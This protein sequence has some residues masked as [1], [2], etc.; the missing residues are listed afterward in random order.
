M[1]KNM[2]DQILDSL[3]SREERLSNYLTENTISEADLMERYAVEGM[4]GR[5]GSFDYHT[6]AK[7]YIESTMREM[8]KGKEGNDIN[9][10]FDKAINSIAMGVKS[11]FVGNREVTN[12]SLLNAAKKDKRVA[13]LLRLDTKMANRTN[14]RLDRNDV[15]QADVLEI[16][17]NKGPVLTQRY[18][19]FSDA[20]R[21]IAKDK[22]WIKTFK[23]TLV[24]SSGKGAEF[25]GTKQFAPT[26]KVPNLKTKYSVDD[27][28][29]GD[30]GGIEKGKKK[31]SVDDGT[32]GDQG[33]IGKKKNL[34]EDV[35]TEGDGGKAHGSKKASCDTSKKKKMSVDTEKEEDSIDEKAVKSKKKKQAKAWNGIK[36]Q[37]YF[38]Y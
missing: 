38:N 33:A 20:V 16:A 34:K 12:K 22:N 4:E 13:K 31:Y 35:G 17:M 32:E 29:E 26:G 6:L 25:E 5:G 8:M 27:K 11:T 15:S 24:A 2:K 30:Q 3:K 18:A 23:N 19:M 14:N 36:D 37:K 21:A 1:E 10:A 28:T 7:Q 9:I